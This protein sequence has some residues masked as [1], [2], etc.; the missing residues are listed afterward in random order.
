MNILNANEDEYSEFY[1]DNIKQFKI[2]FTVLKNEGT[3]NKNIKDRYYG[4]N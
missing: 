2:L 3:T 4:Y 1:N